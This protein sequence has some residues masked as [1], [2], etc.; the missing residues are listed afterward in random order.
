[1]ATTIQQAIIIGGGIG[2]LCTAIALRQIGIDVRVYERTEA[3]ERVGAGLS[4]WANAIG[5]LRKLGLADPVIEAGSVFR[6]AEFR[7]PSGKVLQSGELGTFS[8]PNVGIHRAELHRVLASA[9]PSE[10]LWLGMKCNSVEQDAESVTIHLS[11]GKTDQA[12]LVIAADGLRSVIRQQLFPGTR[13]YNEN[14]TSWR[15]V[16][17]TQDVI[18]PDIVYQTWGRGH[19]FGYLYVDQKHVYWFAVVNLPEGQTLPAAERKDFL[20]RH[21]KGWHHP[22]EHLI[23]MTTADAFLETAIYHIEPLEKWSK[24]RITLLGDAAHAATPDMGQGGCMAIEDA[25]VLARSLSQEKDLASALNR[26]EAERKP[27]TT[28][29][30]K[31]SKAVGRIAQLDNRFLCTLRDFMLTVVPD[32]VMSRQLN[33]AINYE[34]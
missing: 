7:A 24:G 5:A 18:T 13:L 29:I 30:M 11:N 31:Q 10:T 1:M 3:F 20:C 28:W 25:V 15:G 32:K 27:R 26:Y 14:R 9:L 34:V 12:D 4:V 8:E 33:K 6:R 16:A 2:G 21:F 19:R 23:E 22:I 17:A